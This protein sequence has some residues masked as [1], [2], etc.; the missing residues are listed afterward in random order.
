MLVTFPSL[1]LLWLSSDIFQHLVLCVHN[2]TEFA[3]SAE[4][5]SVE[6]TLPHA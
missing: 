1:L 2:G 4:I 5:E 6:L 3:Q